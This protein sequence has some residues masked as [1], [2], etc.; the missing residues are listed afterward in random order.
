MFAEAALRHSQALLMHVNITS[1]QKN[2]WGVMI[3][4]SL[5][6]GVIM[7]AKFEKRAYGAKRI[8]PT[9]TMKFL[10]VIHD[11]HPTRVDRMLI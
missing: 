8:T 10:R 4:L 7:R 5:H 11:C 6:R 9:M 1:D 2:S 3:C